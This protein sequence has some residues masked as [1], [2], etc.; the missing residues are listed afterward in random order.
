MG[1]RTPAPFC[2]CN[3]SRFPFSGKSMSSCSIGGH[4]SYHFETCP[5]FQHDSSPHVPG[6][7]VS[8]VLLVQQLSAVCRLFHLSWAQQVNAPSSP[9]SCADTMPLSAFLLAR[10]MRRFFHQHWHPLSALPCRLC[11]RSRRQQVVPGRCASSSAIASVAMPDVRP[12]APMIHS[13]PPPSYHL[14][15]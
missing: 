7:V 1:G 8:P 12:C 11:A 13:P 10:G 6:W 14:L 15:S 5:F 3:R 4:L 2:S 9:T